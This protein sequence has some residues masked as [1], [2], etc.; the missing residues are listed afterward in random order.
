MRIHYTLTTEDVG[1]PIIRE[2]GQTW[3]VSS[4]IGKILDGDVGK[5]VYPVKDNTGQY[6]FLQVENNEQRAERLA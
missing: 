1:Q 2:F 6:D 3:L 5:H 4:F